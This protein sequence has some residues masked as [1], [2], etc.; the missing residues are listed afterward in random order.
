MDGVDA[1]P[2][3]DAAQKALDLLQKAVEHGFLD[4][5]RLETDSAFELLRK[6]ARFASLVTAT[7]HPGTAPACQAPGE[8]R[9]GWCRRP[10]RSRL[11]RDPELAVVW[12][13]RGWVHLRKGA[14]DQALADLEKAQQLQPSEPQRRYDLARG[15]SLRAA[16]QP[17][18]GE[19][20]AAR[21]QDASRAL[22]ALTQAI[23]RGWKDW[24]KVRLDADLQMLHDQPRFVKLLE[25][26][27]RSVASR[28]LWGR[29]SNHARQQQWEA[30]QA[31]YSRA[32]ELDRDNV[33][34]WHGLA[35]VLR[36]SGQSDAVRQL[37]TD[38]VRQFDKTS[39][40]EAARQA[41]WVLLLGGKAEDATV[42]RALAEQAS[43]KEPD[44]VFG[45]AVL[46]ASLL[47]VGQT[48]EALARLQ[49]IPLAKDQSVDVYAAPWI[50]LAHH[51]LGKPEEASKAL[52]QARTVTAAFLAWQRD[53]KNPD[54]QEWY[55]MNEVELFLREAEGVVGKKP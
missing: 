28:F 9:P 13:T 49:K 47:R 18:T 5:H 25:D 30:S 8:D 10:V 40:A 42:A 20:K 39:D 17:P 26:G 27:D 3:A 12:A 1:T 15:Y 14:W 33:A 41:T 43:A 50:A 7:T 45:Q 32:V 23:E 11:A 19:G 31:D 46:G 4:S 53:S 44:H 2:R 29:A 37:L 35:A 38:L 16:T 22:D 48:Q 36:Q 21:Q 6:D 51:H 54:A 34:A 55:W 52:A 24:D